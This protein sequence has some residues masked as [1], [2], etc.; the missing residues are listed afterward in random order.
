MLKRSMVLLISS[1]LIRTSTLISAQYNN[2]TF[3]ESKSPLVQM[4]SC[5][6]RFSSWETVFSSPCVWYIHWEQIPLTIEPIVQYNFQDF[7][8]YQSIHKLW[9]STGRSTTRWEGN[10]LRNYLS[11][12]QNNEVLSFYEES[13]YM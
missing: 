5:I 7:G 11:S 3:F 13:V 1:I 12:S 10:M 9:I 4:H 6:G 8:S 2:T